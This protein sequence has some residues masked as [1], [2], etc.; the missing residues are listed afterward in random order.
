MLGVDIR[1]SQKD[2][3][4]WTLWE[5]SAF[6]LRLSKSVRIGLK[7]NI[8]LFVNTDISQGRGRGGVKI[9]IITNV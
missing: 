6:V 7:G 3:T 8:E 5:I 9:R 1:C 4:H 2:I